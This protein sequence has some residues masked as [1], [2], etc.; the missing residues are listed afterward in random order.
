MKAYLNKN[1]VY[2]FLLFLLIFSMPFGSYF[3]IFKTS[4]FVMFL[5]RLVLIITAAVLLVN[6]DF[7]FYKGKFSKYFMYIG[8]AWIAYALLSY[9]WVISV[10]YWLKEI[11]SLLSGFLLFYTIHSL[12]YKIQKPFRWLILAWSTAFL[13]QMLFGFWEMY[14]GDHL[15]GNFYKYISNFPYYHFVNKSIITTFDN[16]NN[17]AIYLT[18][19]F[20]LFLLTGDKFKKFKSLLNFFL[21]YVCIVTY[22]G[23]SRI[24]IF[25]LIS[26]YLI[27]IYI[28]SKELVLKLIKSKLYIG[29][30]GLS[31]ISVIYLINFDA[32]FL[33]PDDIGQEV[34]ELY[35]TTLHG[36]FNDSSSSVNIR[37]QLI[38]NGFD[39]FIASKGFGIGSGNFEAYMLN[40]PLK[41]ETAKTINP[42]NWTIQILS[43]YGFFIF[44]PLYLWYLN[45]FVHMYKSLFI[46]L[47]RNKIKFSL[48]FPFLMFIA[49]GILSNLDSSFM[50]NPLNW[51]VLALILI[52]VENKELYFKV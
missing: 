17:L 28:H 30:F 42:H 20:V 15:F 23:S 5:S 4:A 43:Q 52:S 6:R 7:V 40:K 38:L 31:I 51:T 49:Y 32:K 39:F 24:A 48:I 12:L 34:K 9:F 26:V 14:T 50:N 27:Y 36:E 8:V 1:R 41:Y 2:T 22:L 25:A 46:D 33:Y 3:F 29:F 16:P 47:N 45:L 19:S 13:T 10:Q 11:I 44:I 37:K 35:T 21:V 18:F